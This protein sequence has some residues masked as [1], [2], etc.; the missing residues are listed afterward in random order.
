MFHRAYVP[1]LLAMRYC[2]ML[3]KIQNIF[4]NYQDTQQVNSQIAKVYK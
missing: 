4:P 3:N 2:P 1:G